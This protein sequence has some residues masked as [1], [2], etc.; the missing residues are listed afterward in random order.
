[1]FTTGGSSFLFCFL[2][3]LLIYLRERMRDREHMRGG[4]GAILKYVRAL[5]SQQDLP[6]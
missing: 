5:G 3:I 1:M 6:T 4:K 2:K